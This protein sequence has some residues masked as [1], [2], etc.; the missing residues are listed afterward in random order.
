MVLAAV[1]VALAVPTPATAFDVESDSVGNRLYIVVWNRDAGAS[2]DAIQVNVGA[3]SFTTTPTPVSI[4]TSV[5]PDEGRL[6]GFD[7]DVLPSAMLGNSDSVSIS[8]TG[9]VQG[10]ARAAQDV[11]LLDVVAVAPPQQGP[12]GVGT[13]VPGIET[14]DTDG[15][16]FADQE[17]IAAGTDPFDPLSVPPEV[18]ALSDMGVLIVAAAF[19]LT[20]LCLVRLRRVREDA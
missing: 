4:P 2:L 8:I 9:T 10:V 7:F 15:D 12:V 13:G 11:V 20:G 5:P 1:A 3:A 17:E 6:A 19:L 16:G 18:P 14:F